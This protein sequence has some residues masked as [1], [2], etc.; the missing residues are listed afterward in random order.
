MEDDESKSSALQ[1]ETRWTVLRF[2]FAKIRLPNAFSPFHSGRLMRYTLLSRPRKTFSRETG[3]KV[4]KADVSRYKMRP[5]KSFC[6]VSSRSYTNLRRPVS[7]GLYDETL[8]C[9]FDLVP[10]RKN[11]REK[12]QFRVMKVGAFGCKMR[13]GGSFCDIFSRSYNNSKRPVSSQFYSS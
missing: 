8:P 1:N 7:S 10:R 5:R 4:M 3:F 13:L 11:L 6:D 12:L 2:F 9:S